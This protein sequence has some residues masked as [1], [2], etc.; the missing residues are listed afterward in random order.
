MEGG[1]LASYDEAWENDLEGIKSNSGEGKGY[2]NLM[3]QLKAEGKLGEDATAKDAYIY[4]QTNLGSNESVHKESHRNVAQS[5]PE[6]E[7]YGV[8]NIGVKQDKSQAALDEMQK[9]CADQGGTYNRTSG[10]CN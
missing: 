10:A 2:H 9:Q 8:D 4:E 7:V 5:N 1:R 3:S 6:G